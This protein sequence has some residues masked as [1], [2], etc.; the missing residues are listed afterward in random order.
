MGQVQGKCSYEVYGKFHHHDQID[1]ARRKAWKEHSTACLNL[2][3]VMHDL[4]LSSQGATRYRAK[5]T[6]ATFMVQEGTKWIEA[7]HCCL[8]LNEV[9]HDRML[10]T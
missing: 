10:V 1:S 7:S 8:D 6:L 4:L 5:K 9:M 2:W 3:T